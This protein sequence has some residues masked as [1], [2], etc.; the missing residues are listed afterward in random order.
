MITVP[1]TEAKA[2]I[3]G[4]VERLLNMKE[5]VIITKHGRPAAALI[6]YEEWEEL[7]ASKSGG[8]ASVPPPAADDDA[9]VDALVDGIYEARAK[10]RPRKAAL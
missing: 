1:I 3:S 7:T 8:L 6:P 5:H 9:A 2:R 4:L 10:A